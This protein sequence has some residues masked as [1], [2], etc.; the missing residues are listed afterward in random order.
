[1]VALAAKYASA[2]TDPSVQDEW[3]SEAMA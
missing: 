2:E 3:A 1:L